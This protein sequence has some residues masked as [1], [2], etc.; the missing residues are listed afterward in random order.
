MELMLKSTLSN[1]F[2]SEW[3]IWTDIGCFR[4]RNK[5]VDIDLSLIKNWPN[6]TKLD[7][8]LKDKINMVLVVPP[9]KKD[10]FELHPNGISKHSIE[11]QRCI[12]ATIF[13]LHISFVEQAYKEFFNT[14]DK[15]LEMK[16]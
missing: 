8:L 15:C 9:N 7:Q 6:E 14:L 1:P 12:S 5:K 2:K 4:N 10:F 13:I 3:F 16:P 11:F